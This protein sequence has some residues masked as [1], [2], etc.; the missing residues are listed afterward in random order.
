M[1][2]AVASARRRCPVGEA[3][4]G[5]AGH[6]VEYSFLIGDAEISGSR[7]GVDRFTA[8]GLVDG[9]SGAQRLV[10]KKDWPA[11]EAQLVADF[12]GPVDSQWSE[13]G[14]L[15][16][17]PRLKHGKRH[18]GRVHAV[19]GISEYLIPVVQRVRVC[20]SPELAAQILV[21]DGIAESLRGA[22]EIQLCRRIQ[23]S[24][25]IA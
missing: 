9:P 17:V 6:E 25:G 19:L 22:E 21:S 13:I 16:V 11:G 8:G 7:Y 10:D 15:H 2:K 14:V 12:C 1:R 4:E 23:V 20:D 24:D 3:G 18:A 5:I